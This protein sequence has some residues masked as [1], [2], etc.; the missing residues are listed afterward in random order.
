MPQIFFDLPASKIS[1][2][3]GVVLFS[4]IHMRDF[5]ITMKKWIQRKVKHDFMFK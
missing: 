4:K 1:I 2:K 3:I 5:A